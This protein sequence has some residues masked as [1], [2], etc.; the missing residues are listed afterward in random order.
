MDLLTIEEIIKIILYSALI[1]GATQGIKYI[2]ENTK[3]KQ[4]NIIRAIIREG[5]SFAQEVYE[6]IDGERKYREALKYIESRLEKLNI[7]ISKDDLYKLI[8]SVLKEVKGELGI[9]WDESEDK[10]KEED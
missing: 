8:N 3:E 1:Y 9:E 6:E 2:Q 5:V 4:L 7:D 10:N